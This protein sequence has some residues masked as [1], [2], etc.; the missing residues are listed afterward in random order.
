[1]LAGDELEALG[2][3]T[4]WE[5]LA[6]VP[7][8]QPVRSGAAPSTIVRGIQF[9][10]NSGNLK[11]LLD[12]VPLTRQSSAINSSLLYLPIRQVER[13]EVIRGPG[14]VIYG[15]FAFMGLI[16]VITRRDGQEAHLRLD[17]DGLFGAGAVVALGGG[18][19]P[20]RL[21]ANVAAG[22][23]EEATLP[24][25]REG[26]EEGGSAVAS[27]ERGGFT[28]TGQA[29]QHEVDDTSPPGTPGGPVQLEETSWSLDARYGRDLLPELRLAGYATLL[30]ADYT[31]S[32]FTLD[33]RVTR[34]GLDL[35]WDGWSGQSWLAGVEYA[36]QDIHRAT[37]NLPGGGPQ[38]HATSP[39]WCCR[40]AST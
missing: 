21:S 37:A 28:F 25:A 18:E 15:D 7:G 32:Q 30:G 13:I 9:P 5:A 17:D 3:G 19:S 33:D 4:V 24:G 40:T 14:S 2:F 1:V 8:I 34:G 6:M 10:F 22:V 38:F 29:F 23:D 27:V 20:W 26:E 36:A 12:G 31:S 35:T 16:N 11:I 39:R